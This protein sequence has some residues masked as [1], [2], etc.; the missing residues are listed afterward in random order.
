MAECF[1]GAGALVAL[2][3]PLLLGVQAA[4]GLLALRAGPKPAP[5]LLSA[6][7]GSGWLLPD[8]REAGATPDGC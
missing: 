2:L 4:H 8:T 1:L 5:L 7:A 6:A 3:P